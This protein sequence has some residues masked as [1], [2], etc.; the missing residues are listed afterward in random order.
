MSVPYGTTED[1]FEKQ[2]GINHLGHFALTG[3]LLDRIKETPKSRVVTM[4]SGAHTMANIDFKNL[5]YDGGRKY[6]PSTAYGRSKLA[7]LLFTY[8]LQHLF[9]NEKI[10]ATTLAAHPGSAN[11]NLNNHL[12]DSFIGN[13]MAPMMKAMFQSAAL[14]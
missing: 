9:E 8:E 10:D 3:L 13:I 4:S 12:S 11:T 5:Q 6:I 7:N 2:F 14:F 1:G